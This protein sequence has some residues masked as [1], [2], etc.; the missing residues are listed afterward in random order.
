MTVDFPAAQK[1]LHMG[2]KKVT[3]MGLKHLRSPHS[4][5]DQFSKSNLTIDLN[6]NFFQKSFLKRVNQSER[7]IGNQFL[8]YREYPSQP[9]TEKNFFGKQAFSK[10]KNKET[11]GKSMSQPFD[12]LREESN[13]AIHNTNQDNRNAT[14]EA[15]LY[16]N[17]HYVEGF[18]NSEFECNKF[19]SVMKKKNR[20]G[21]VS[22]KEMLGRVKE[23]EEI[24]TLSETKQTYNKNQDSL[25]HTLFPETYEQSVEVSVLKPS[26]NSKSNKHSHKSNVTEFELKEKTSYRVS[27]SLDM[28]SRNDLLNDIRTNNNNDFGKLSVQMDPS[29]EKR[30]INQSISDDE[31]LVNPLGGD[32]YAELSND[33]DSKDEGEEMKDLVLQFIET[34]DDQNLEIIEH[35]G[36]QV[37][38]QRRPALMLSSRNSKQFNTSNDDNDDKQI[39]D[40][41]PICSKGREYQIF[42]EFGPIQGDIAQI[43]EL[44]VMNGSSPMFGEFPVDEPVFGESEY[45]NFIA[46]SL[47]Y[48]YFFN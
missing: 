20:K 38:R 4:G 6:S 48:H 2:H 10:Q 41:E 35:E 15:P 26:C 43:D 8:S 32:T 28:I 16:K 45:I 42:E 11:R 30:D 24:E 34:P 21:F 27:E 22:T 33:S 19:V 17:N 23:H 5:M 39:M 1:M 46:V 3:S 18:M 12:S 47:I 36:V 44:E 7:N 37:N 40:F 25:R 31:S 29:K 14:E 13:R 9:K